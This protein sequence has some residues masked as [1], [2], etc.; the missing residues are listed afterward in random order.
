MTKT[1]RYLEIMQQ[2]ALKELLSPEPIKKF[3]PEVMKGRLKLTRPMQLAN[4]WLD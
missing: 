4:G 3:Q 1:Q 2:E